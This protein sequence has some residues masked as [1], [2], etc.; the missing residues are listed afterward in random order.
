MLKRQSVTPETPFSPANEIRRQSPK[1]RRLQSWWVRLFLVLLSGVLGWQIWKLVVTGYQLNPWHFNQLGHETVHWSWRGPTCPLE[2]KRH[3]WA[4]IQAGRKR[5]YLFGEWEQKKVMKQLVE[6][7]TAGSPGMQEMLT[8]TPCDLW[9]LA[10]EAELFG[11]V[12][13]SMNAAK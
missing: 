12:G 2:Y 10:G 13:D 5:P 3:Q 1:Q 11:L 9:P 8:L 7:A 4:D 6:R